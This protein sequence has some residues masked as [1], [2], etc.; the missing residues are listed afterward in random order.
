MAASVIGVHGIWNYRKTTPERAAEEI[1]DE[2]A[3]SLDLVPR[4]SLAAAYYSNVL[5]LP[6]QGPLDDI[7]AINRSLNGLPETVLLELMEQLGFVGATPQG[8]GGTPIRQL[9]SWFTQRYKL[10]GPLVENLVRQFVTE[11]SIYMHPL[12]HEARRAAQSLVASFI[13]SH[14]PRIVI[15]HSLGSVVAYEAF[16]AYPELRTELL[17][18]IGSPLALPTQ[19]FEKLVPTPADGRGKRPPGVARWINFADVG[20]IVAIPK[21]LSKFFDGLDLDNEV[22]AGWMC[23]HS[24]STYLG[25]VELRNVVSKHLAGT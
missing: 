6:S 13:A 21:N 1:A 23:T 4:D 15:A 20:D 11:V 10:D 3:R 7:E 18:T 19:I 17:I 24:C 2:W 9:L 25:T 8:V 5:K 22:S 16:W 14:N 12:H